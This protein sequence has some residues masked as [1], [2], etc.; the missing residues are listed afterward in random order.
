MLRRFLWPIIWELVNVAA[1]TGVQG[2]DL[3]VVAYRR[4]CNTS[5]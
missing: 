3:M 4:Y 1:D 5:H 2:R